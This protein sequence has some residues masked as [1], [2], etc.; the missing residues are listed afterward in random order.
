MIVGGRVSESLPASPGYI[1]AYDVRSGALRWTFRTIPATRRAGPRHLA[2][3]CLAYIGG[4]NSWAGHDAGRKT[5]RWCSCPPVRPRRISTARTV[6]A[7]TCTPIACWRWTRP[8]ASCAG[9]SSSSQHDVLDR[10]LPSAPTLVT[11]QRDGKAVDALVQTTKQGYVFVLDRDTGQPVFPV[12]E[13]PAPPSDVPGERRE[14]QLP[15]PQRAGALARQR[16][17]ADDPDHAHARG[18]PLGARAVRRTAQRR[19]LQTADHRVS[20]RLST[21]AS[22]AAPNGAARRTTRKPACC[23]STP[24]RW[25]GSARS[26]R[27]TSG[28]APASPSTCANA[29]PAT[30]TACRD[31]RRSSRR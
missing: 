15:A 27:T 4:A 31:R 11:L 24:T 9:T 18:Q 23:T 6:S 2:T 5:R 14:P 19:P 20:T 8:P 16:L 21:R 28:A 17:S 13:V 3:G 1:R 25:P 7:T 12:E 22:T 30:A 29:P 26:R 10:D